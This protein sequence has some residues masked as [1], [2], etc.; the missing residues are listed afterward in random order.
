MGGKDLEHRYTATFLGDRAKQI[1][2]D[3]QDFTREASGE[4]VRDEL[5]R[6][7]ASP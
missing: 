4:A 3:Q 6:P 7:L 2:L 1:M 5:D